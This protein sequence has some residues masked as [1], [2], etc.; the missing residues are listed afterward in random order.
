VVVLYRRF[1]TTYWS[2]VQGDLLTLEYGTD[3]L[4]RNVGTELPLN[5]VISQKSVHLV[6]IAAEA[7]DHDLDCGYSVPLPLD[8]N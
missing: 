1:G 6:H 3:R 7:R 4:S 5:C 8:A 2:H